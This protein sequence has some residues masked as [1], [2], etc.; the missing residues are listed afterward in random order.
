MIHRII[1]LLHRLKRDSLGYEGAAIYLKCAEYEVR[2]SLIGHPDFYLED[3]FF[4]YKKDPK[5]E[6]L[7]EI[8]DILL[9]DSAYDSMPRRTEMAIAQFDIRLIKTFIKNNLGFNIDIINEINS[10][11]AGYHVAFESIDDIFDMAAVA[12][13]VY[14]VERAGFNADEFIDV[15]YNK[16]TKRQIEEATGMKFKNKAEVVEFLKGHELKITKS[17]GKYTIRKMRA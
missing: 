4:V 2:R 7:K 8:K 14:N 9:D 1:S 15:L 16:E 12:Y 11:V 3:N 5:E 6:I 13:S 17:S 10:N